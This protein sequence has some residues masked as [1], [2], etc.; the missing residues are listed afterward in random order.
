MQKFQL[1]CDTTEDMEVLS[2]ILS[3]YDYHTT[4][5]RAS[6]IRL[7]FWDVSGKYEQKLTGVPRLVVTEMWDFIKRDNVDIL[8]IEVPTCIVD[9]LC[10]DEYFA[11]YERLRNILEE[12]AVSVSEKYVK[13]PTRE[14]TLEEATAYGS[15]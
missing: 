13:F 1:V 12:I 7:Q 15:G 11:E 8:C 3:S 2:R 5:N 9:L 10:L 4:Q 6:C 14:L